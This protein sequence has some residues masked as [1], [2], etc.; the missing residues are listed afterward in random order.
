[1]P[2]FDIP[3]IA[4]VDAANIDEA[5]QAVYK[6]I[7]GDELPANTELALADDTLTTR[8]NQRVVILHPEDVANDYD[9]NEY[10]DKIKDEE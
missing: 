4:T 10:N 5:R 2:K 8:T 1:M 6:S 9:V 3:V 7:E